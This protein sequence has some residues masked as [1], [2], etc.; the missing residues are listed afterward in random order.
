MQ[1]LAL[2]LGQVA[3]VDGGPGTVT[4]HAHLLDGHGLEP[5]LCGV[6]PGCLEVLRVRLGVVARGLLD[7]QLRLG[8]RR[9]VGLVDVPDAV[10]LGEGLAV[11]GVVAAR[12]VAVAADAVL[13]GAVHDEPRVRAAA[14][15]GC[16]ALD[17]PL[18][19]AGQPAVGVRR[20]R[21][22]GAAGDGAHGGLAV[23]H[24]SVA[25]GVA[26][27]SSV[28]RLRHTPSVHRLSVPGD[29]GHDLRERHPKVV[30]RDHRVTVRLRQVPQTREQ[31]QHPLAVRLGRQRC[32]CRA[33]PRRSSGPTPRAGRGSAGPTPAS[34]IGPVASRVMSNAMASVG[35]ALSSHGAASPGATR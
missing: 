1:G 23:V 14:G 20:H 19:V 3:A 12:A 13:G 34:A 2:R 17:E 18:A 30:V 4:G 25:V 24:E 9:G 22:C 32:R 33:S 27:L 6:V 35:P 11:A 10:D 31:R 8:Q 5:L 21:A 29:A 28:Q 26:G 16:A 15:H 7:G